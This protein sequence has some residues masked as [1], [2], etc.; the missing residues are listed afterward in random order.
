LVSNL[1]VQFD[2]MQF[3]NRK[4]NQGSETTGK[5]FV[6][7]DTIPLRIPEEFDYI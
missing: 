4:A 6:R 7:Q 1:L 2:L 3:G 5:N